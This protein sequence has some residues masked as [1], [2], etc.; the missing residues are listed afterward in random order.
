[1]RRAA[2]S[3]ATLVVL[4]SFACSTRTSEDP[5]QAAARRHGVEILALELRAGGDLA[6]L[7]Y[8]VVD[9]E[10]AKVALRDEMSLRTGDGK[11]SLPILSLSRLG[12]MTQRPSRAGTRQFVLFT[13]PGRTLMKGGTAVLSI[14]GDQIG[15]IPIS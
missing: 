14:G 6:Q 3:A 10:I 7:S 13:N 4:A 8:R 5:L 2:L 1:V 12:P 15:A 11:G 9:F